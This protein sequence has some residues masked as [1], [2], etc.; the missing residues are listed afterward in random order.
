MSNMLIQGGTVVDGNGTPARQVDVR[1]SNGIIVELAPSLKP[2]ADEQ[3]FDASGYLVTPGFVDVHTHYD[4]Q[5]TWDDQLAPSCWHGVTTVVMGNCGVGFAPVHPDEHQRLINLMEGV[6]DIPGSALSEG[7]TWGWESFPEYLDLL[8][9][10]RWM[11]DVGTH[12]P[13]SAVRHYVMGDRAATENATSQEIARMC[14]IMREGVEQGA[15]GV[16]TSR[17]LAHRDNAGGVVPGTYTERAEFEAIVGEL[18]KIGKGV[19]QLIPRGMDGEVSEV[20]HAEIEW[21]GDIA[22]R[23]GRPVLF[24]VMQTHTELDRWRMLLD[25]A[26]RLQAQGIPLYPQVGA[27]PA[28]I[29]FGLQSFQHTFST[30]PG[31][32][33][34]EHLPL[35]ERVAEMRKPEVRARILAEPNGTYRH[36]M[37]QMLH[38]DFTHMFP[39]QPPIDLE[40]TRD[41]TVVALAKLRGITPEELCYEHLLGN[42]GHNLIQYP[43]TNYYH[44]SLDD[45]HD[46]LVHPATHFGLGDGGAHCGVA[47][48]AGTPT[49]MLSYWSRDRKRGPK[50]DIAT[51][52]RMITRDTAELYGL[53]DRGRIAP[54]YRADINVMDYDK[55]QLQLPE[56]VFDLPTGARRLMQRA[57]GYVATFVAGERTID[58]D[59]ATGALPGR[60]IRGAQFPEKLNPGEAA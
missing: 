48:D 29:V 45:V 11:M 3:L 16:S 43:I 36:P 4:G 9:S 32:K 38:E 53:Q 60:L 39:V 12:V 14:A 34:I 10:R 2:L 54:G 47:C 50:I 59:N 24:G 27:R 20:A 56:M 1:V 51:A 30:R 18:S 5:A 37:A 6:E 41:N 15:L 35:A 52:V 13:H 46:M 21:M 7:M 31:Y 17:L 55:L 8:E 49:M 19:F 40:P 22:A 44:Y 57:S 26:A 42:D 58:C 23:T 33:A 28:G 25:H